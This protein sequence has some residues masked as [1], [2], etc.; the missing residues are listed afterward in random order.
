MHVR[1]NTVVQLLEGGVS[2]CEGVL[3]LATKERGFSP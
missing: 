2:Q 3:E 1:P